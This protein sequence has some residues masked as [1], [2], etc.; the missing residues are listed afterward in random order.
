MQIQHFVLNQR[1]TTLRLTDPLSDD[2]SLAEDEHLRDPCSW[3]S[4][5]RSCR[6]PRRRG[7]AVGAGGPWGAY[8]YTLHPAP[9]A[10]ASAPP[11]H[12]RQPRRLNKQ[13]QQTSLALNRRRSNMPTLPVPWSRVQPHAAPRDAGV[14]ALA[15]RWQVPP[16]TARVAAARKTGFPLEKSVAKIQEQVAAGWQRRDCVAP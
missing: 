11:V 7:G 10:R 6:A 15:P 2:G 8:W 9:V 3:R 4:S 12:H 5:G 14:L 16:S 1:Q 13:I